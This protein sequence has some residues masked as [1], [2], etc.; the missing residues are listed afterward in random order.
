[1]NEPEIKVIKPEGGLR[2]PQINWPKWPHIKPAILIGVTLFLA[3]VSV[4]T[5]LLLY[6]RRAEPIAPTA[7]A[8][9]PKAQVTTPTPT[10][11][12]S[13][14]T[15]SFTIS[16]TPSPGPTPTPT[17]SPGPTPTPTVTPTPTPTPT[18][19]GTPGPTPTPTPLGTPRPTPTP[20][21]LVQGPTPTPVT[22]EAAGS[23]AGTWTV[24]LAGGV[25]LLLG[26]ILMFAL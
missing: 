25:L 10:P 7:P 14:C 6:Q 12:G 23:V 22:L 20:T 16:A 18:P 5:A 3:V 8:S 4:V 15:V 11:V 19:G 1:M 17:T 9:K 2:L 24:S 26:S 21:P 13:L